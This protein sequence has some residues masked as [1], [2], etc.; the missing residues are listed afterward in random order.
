MFLAKP[1][2]EYATL[3]L[4]V[5]GKQLMFK[6]PEEKLAYVIETAMAA[7]IKIRRV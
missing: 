7:W 2:A 6:L 3:S 4:V 1:G 5:D